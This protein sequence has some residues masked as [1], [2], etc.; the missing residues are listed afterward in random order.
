MKVHRPRD[1]QP[2]VTICG[3][4]RHGHVIRASWDMTV[5]T[6]RSCRAAMKHGHVVRAHLH[7]KRKRRH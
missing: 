7:T 3:L 4:V 2:G 6:C 1:G 5:V